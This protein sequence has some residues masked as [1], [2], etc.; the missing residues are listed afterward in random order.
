VES[1]IK[2]PEQAF[3]RSSNRIEK[4]KA[5][6]HMSDLF[7]AFPNEKE[8]SYL[9]PQILLTGMFSREIQFRSLE[10]S[11]DGYLYDITVE[12]DHSFIIEGWISHNCGPG[13]NCTFEFENKELE[14]LAESFGHPEI[15]AEGEGQGP[16]GYDTL[17]PSE[18]K[19]FYKIQRILDI[20]LKGGPG[21]GNFGH[22]GRPG[23]VGGSGPGGG[24]GGEEDKELQGPWQRVSSADE[25]LKLLEQ[26]KYVELDPN[27][28]GTVIS[29]MADAAKQAELLG[30]SAPKYNLCNISVAGTNVFCGGGEATRPR[31]TMPRI[32]NS[33]AK[34]F[35]KYLQKKG[36]D[37]EK[38]KVSVNKLKASQREIDGVK[39]AQKM[40]EAKAGGKNPLDS[41]IFVSRDNFI[42]DGHH[43][44]ATAVGLNYDHQGSNFKM[45]VYRV[46]LPITKLYDLAN[47]Y[48]DKMGYQRL[49]S[50]ESSYKKAV[51][52]YLK[53]GTASSGN[54]GHAGRPGEVGGSGPGGELDLKQEDVDKWEKISEA[55]GTNKGGW[56]EAPNGDKFYAKFYKNPEQGNAEQAANRAYRAAG[57]MAPQTGEVHIAGQQGIAS[58][59]IETQQLSG[60]KLN[61]TLKDNPEEAGR[62]F[63]ASVATQNWDV[64]G[65]GFDNL[66]LGPGGH[67]V[68][69]DN[70]GS[71][72][73][74]AQGGFK[75]WNEK[76]DEFNNLRNPDKNFYA[77]KAFEGVMSDPAAVASAKE[78]VQAMREKSDEITA[79]TSVTPE[80][81]EAKLNDL[82]QKLNDQQ[83]LIQGIKEQMYGKPVTK[84]EEEPKPGKT[85]TKY[86][87]IEGHKATAVVRYLSKSG[88]DKSQIQSVLTH[89]G[90]SMKP[91][92]LQTQM[93]MGKNDV[94]GKAE[95]TPFQHSGFA[96]IAGMTTT[97]SIPKES[98]F[99]PEKEQGIY[100][101]Q[102]EEQKQETKQE[103]IKTEQVKEEINPFSRNAAT[104]IVRWMGKQ[105]Y[106]A[107]EVQQVLNYHGVKLSPA[108]I[109]TQLSWGK[110]GKMA[111]ADVN[112]EEAAGISK[113]ISGGFGKETS[114]SGH[115]AGSLPDSKAGATPQ[116]L[117]SAEKLVSQY[118][119]E[120][121]NYQTKDATKA[122]LTNHLID[123]A[124]TDPAVKSQFLQMSKNSQLQG[125]YS[126]QS[127]TDDQRLAYAAKMAASNFV[128]RWAGTS[129]DSSPTSL[130]MQ[131][132]VANKF[133]LGQKVQGSQ[134]YVYTNL[135][136]EIEKWGLNSQL[137]KDAHNPV[138]AGQVLGNSA[139]FKAYVDKQYDATQQRLKA[140]GI[141]ELSLYRGM[142]GSFKP[143][144]EATAS[145]FTMNPLTSFSQTTSTASS[146]GSNKF[147]STFPI[148]RIFSYPKTGPG[149]YGEEEFVI[150]G[151]KITTHIGKWY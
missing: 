66:L 51:W 108:T 36:V 110:I 17:Y 5:S 135:K 3:V 13:C 77:A 117:Q 46:D 38:D 82:D 111:P 120:D 144:G 33:D 50:G 81:F 142:G 58:K 23:E 93:W 76:A 72:T 30:K 11:T 37:F 15:G 47:K 63:A 8:N 71:F 129:G 35:A 114:T 85:K 41:R 45:K 74:R 32:P 147:T 14:D 94:G 104:S 78:A 121:S 52:S 60:E 18:P 64:V 112:Q 55:M 123:A 24:E 69:I 88:F 62:I 19:S 12:R 149:C 102:Q 7:E 9:L 43:K 70:G 16:E 125:K 132:A 21:S 31:I 25:A 96:Q 68:P 26:G 84:E 148:E 4:A 2:N 89:Y 27:Q 48:T 101:K 103:E 98:G 113:I 61:Q 65:T 146:F 39:V 87:D 115:E 92:T 141:K 56:Y 86:D 127:F 29:K 97:P 100:G 90:I 151:G 99:E 34:G 79:G 105:G 136:D 42:I 75:P 10:K 28:V 107:K 59:A 1:R 140:E 91:G 80:Q 83:N 6:S 130:G 124:K 73:F 131:Q 139:V 138:E 119:K 128:D 109:K 53:Y 150:V 57:V 67:L 134:T 54:Y 22:A 116:G 143:T 126:L 49:G 44:W 40:V 20:A 106:S 133:G 95:V 145:H 137:I 122:S 118:Q